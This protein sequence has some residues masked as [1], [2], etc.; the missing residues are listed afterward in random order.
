MLW[1]I[2]SGASECEIS[3]ATLRKY[4]VSAGHEIS[5]SDRG[6]AG[7]KFTTLQIHKALSGDK[8]AAMTRKLQAEADEQERENRVANGELIHIDEAAQVYGRKLQAMCQALDAMGAQ[9]DSRLAAETTPAGC[10]KMVNEY[11]EQ[12]KEAGRSAP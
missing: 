7:Q 12:I 1:T 9:L 11:I 8:N 10:R 5:K 4:L 3:E 6:K 2:F